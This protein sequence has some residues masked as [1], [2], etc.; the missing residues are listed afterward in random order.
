VS[1]ET[2]PQNGQMIPAQVLAQN[3]RL[4]DRSVRAHHCGQKVRAA[5]VHEHC[6]LPSSMA[7][8]EGSLAFFFPAFD[9]LLVALV[10]ST[11]RFLQAQ[12]QGFEQVAYAELFSEHLRHPRARPPLSPKPMRAHFEYLRED[13]IVVYGCGPYRVAGL[14]EITPLTC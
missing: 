3:R 6:G 11:R 14:A 2:T 1:V 4:T 7:P 5:L 12:P 9:R 13:L 10:G 8:F